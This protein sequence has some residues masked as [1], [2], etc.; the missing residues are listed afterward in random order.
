MF[1][2][3]PNDISR[4]FVCK[5]LLRLITDQ[6]ADSKTP[7]AHLLLEAVPLSNISSESP[8]RAAQLFSACCC[9]EHARLA[10]KVCK[11]TISSHFLRLVGV[12]ASNCI[13]C[14]VELLVI[15]TP[16]SGCSSLFTQADRCR[17]PAAVQAVCAQ[18]VTGE[19][20]AYTCSGLASA[21]S[22]E[23]SSPLHNCKGSL[24]GFHS[25]ESYNPATQVQVTMAGREH[26]QEVS[27][28]AHQLLGSGI[29]KS[30]NSMQRY[31]Q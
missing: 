18:P 27:Y 20:S 10:V 7:T 26:G 3:V 11:C 12:L 23:Y 4:D 19:G 17:G 29:V 30:Q 13:D 16:I 8:Q 21:F 28:V 31:R 25:A 9:A 6:D 2:Q 5:A 22:S 14:D 1:V 15:V 24:G